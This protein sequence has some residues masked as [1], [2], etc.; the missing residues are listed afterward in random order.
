MD[1]R[2][3]NNDSYLITFGPFSM[4]GPGFPLGPSEPCDGEAGIMPVVG[5]IY[6]RVRVEI[7]FGP[8]SP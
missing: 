2:R 7:T 3:Q 6:F 5:T 4:M 1:C 8:G